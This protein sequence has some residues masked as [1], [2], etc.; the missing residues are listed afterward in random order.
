MPWFAA[1]TEVVVDALVTVQCGAIHSA[2]EISAIDDKRFGHGRA[3]LE[4]STRRMFRNALL[5]SRAP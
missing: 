1:I 5:V 4:H 3:E 2:T